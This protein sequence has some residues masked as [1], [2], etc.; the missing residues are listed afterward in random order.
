M[1]RLE[2]DPG[3]LRRA[4]ELWWLNPDDAHVLSVQY[5]SMK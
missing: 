2:G 5:E 3:R 4:R 1:G